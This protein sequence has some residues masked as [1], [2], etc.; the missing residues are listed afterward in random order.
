[1]LYNRDV[2]A[3]LCGDNRVESVTTDVSDTSIKN[4]FQEDSSSFTE[5]RINYNQISWTSNLTGVIG[6]FSET[7]GLAPTETLAFPTVLTCKNGS[8][9]SWTSVD[10]I[11]RVPTI[12]IDWRN[13]ETRSTSSANESS[14]RVGYRCT[15]SALS[16]WP[17]G[18]SN[19]NC[20]IMILNFTIRK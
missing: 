20:S 9:F 6:F 11:Y 19:Y 18:S 14:I 7:S 2:L 10:P 16:P 15:S 13:N 4:L 12:Q 8:N 5:S 17:T 1:M 3:N